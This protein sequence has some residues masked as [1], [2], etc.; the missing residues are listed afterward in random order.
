MPGLLV[1]LAQLLDEHSEILQQSEFKAL[2]LAEQIATVQQS[3][4]NETKELLTLLAHH[5]ELKTI[6]LGE[7]PAILIYAQ[8]L[9]PRIANI[10][11]AS[12]NGHVLCTVLNS[13]KPI[14]IS[15]R[16]YFQDANRT[17]RFSVGQFQHDRSIN[18][19]TVNFA[20]PV[21]NDDKQVLHTLVVAQSLTKWSYAL[22]KLP[23]PAGSKVMISDKQHNI[24]A[25]YPFKPEQLGQPLNL[26]WPSSSHKAEVAE[27]RFGQNRI[28][29]QLPLEPNKPRTSL[30]IHF[31]LPFEQAINAANQKVATTLSLFIL[32]IVI[33]IWQAKWQLNRVLLKPL[34][35]LQN[36]MSQFTNSE[37]VNWGKE[38]SSPEFLAITQ[39]FE[40]MANTRLNAEQAL[41]H[42]HAELIALLTAL[43]DS[44]LRINQSGEILMSHGPYFQGAKAIQDIF[45]THVFKRVLAQL[46]L[47]EEQPYS[48]LEFSQLADDN[49]QHVYECRINHISEHQQAILIIRDISQRKQ[50]EEAISLAALVYKNSS[51]G[52]VITDSNGFILDTN[53]AFSEVTGFKREE[54]IGKTTSI[55]SSGKHNKQF[56]S[57]MWQQ[58]SEQ[59]RW[60]GEIINRRKNGELYTEWLTIN[61]VYNAHNEAYRR[62]AIFTDITDRKRKDELIWHQAHFDQLTELANRIELKRHLK[63]QLED[64]QAN[65]GILLLDLDHFKDINDTLGHYYGDQLLTEVASRLISLQSE[66][67]L[68]SRIGG[69]EFVLVT[70][71]NDCE[72][73]S[74]TAEKVLQLL[75]P[76]I[77]LGQE[78]CHISASIGIAHAP[79]DGDSSEL[80]LKAADQAMYQ[81]KQHGR[82]GFAFFSAHMREQAE[83]RMALLKDLRVALTQQQ[84]ILYYQPIVAMK[85]QSIVKAE[86]LIRWR[87]PEKGIVSPALFIPLA[88]ETQLIHGIGE[89]IFSTA[90]DTLCALNQL[91]HHLQLSINVSPVQFTAKHS[92]LNDWHQQLT[93]K[94][95]TTEQFVIEITE[96]LMMNA[97]PRT[98][99]RLTTLTKQGFALA[100]DD[101]GTGYSSLAYLK[102]MDTDFI[103][104]DK[105]F[106]D[107][108][109][110]TADDLA[111]CEAMI[112]MA[113]QLGLKVIAEGIETATQHQLLLQAGCDFGQGFYYAK[114]MPKD[115]LVNLLNTA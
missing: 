24:I 12:P 111:L 57:Q 84:F 102:Q 47:L 4:I 60:Q 62:V 72:Q 37:P 9:A 13:A 22:A 20:I 79:R 81:A 82:N 15:D 88:E 18:K 92:A 21:L 51:E 101:F 10:G 70:T 16:L 58:L 105:R 108:I 109:A 2:L 38:Q 49:T 28:Y 103:K 5:P 106:V 17:K 87:H 66:C 68:I 53:P 112:M 89:F 48:Q 32:A 31:S 19:A 76:S 100:L 80:L 6:S 39:Q 42:K 90:C 52:M 34:K 44:Y 93:N 65:V 85:D 115:E 55:L 69:D 75:K 3:D 97:L 96:G 33:I 113:H 59:G 35:S 1:I 41:T 14:D 26:S 110:H 83:H 104:I 46:A 77:S 74:K 8:A 7:C 27:D 61:S 99:Q 25:Q 11:I 95:L 67:S 36:A 114:P 40:I 30:Q 54:V 43:P 86:A 63:C 91:G 56:Y 71:Y 23:L 94:G 73:L 64:D 50:H 45:P 78:Q 107:G 98:Q 29:L